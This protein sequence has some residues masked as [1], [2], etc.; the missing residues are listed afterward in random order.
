[1]KA[2][3]KVAGFS[4]HA[5]VAARA[6]QRRKLKR[7][8]RHISQAAIAKKRLSL[9]PNGNVRYQLKTPYRD[10]ATHKILEPVDFIAQPAALCRN[11]G[12]TSH[13]FMEPLSPHCIIKFCHFRRV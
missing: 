10:G 3:A 5:D 4:L 1:M 8:C 9:T 13:L 2:S 11:R 12:S 7:L 6:D